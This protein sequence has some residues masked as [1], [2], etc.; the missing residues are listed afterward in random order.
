MV[1]NSTGTRR[2]GKKNERTNSGVSSLGV[3]EISRKNEVL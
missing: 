3:A 1:T 2:G